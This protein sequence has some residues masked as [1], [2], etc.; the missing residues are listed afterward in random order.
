MTTTVTHTRPTKKDKERLWL[1][2]FRAAYQ[3]EFPAGNVRNG[4]E[5]EKPD[6]IIVDPAWTTGIEITEFH[7]VDGGRPESEK[8]QALRRAGVVKEAQGLYLADGGKNMEFTFGFRYISA[9]RRRKLPSELF[10]FAKRIENS[11]SETIWLEGNAAPE[12]V[13]FA[14][15]SG[16]YQNAIWKAQQVHEGSLT[17]KNK[18]IEIVRRKEEKAKGY[19]KCDAY[20]LLI[21]VNFFDPAQDQEIRIDDPHVHSEVFDKIFMFKSV[22]NHIVTVK[23]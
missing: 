7:L 1:E 19:Q 17:S 22:F 16:E 15:N 12:E 11:V 8:Q 18:L 13:A 23:G 10:A 4:D 3:G 20:W 5:Q 21:C 6:T 2:H 14:W 9:G